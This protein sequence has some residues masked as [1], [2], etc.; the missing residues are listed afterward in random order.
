MLA[1]NRTESILFLDLFGAVL[2]LIGTIA[3][4]AS[5]AVLKE[6]K[7]CCNPSK[8]DLSGRAKNYLP[9]CVESTIVVTR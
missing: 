9:G 5:I 7:A 1:Y 6:Q 4:I 3:V 2:M 8:L